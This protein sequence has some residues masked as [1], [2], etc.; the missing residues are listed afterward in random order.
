MPEEGPIKDRAK[1]LGVE[2]YVI[3]F[4]TVNSIKRP[5]S[6]IKGLSA[7]QSLVQTSLKLS[8]LTR[9]LNISIVHSNG[10]KAHFINCVAY[11]FFGGARSVVHIRDIPYTKT[12]II[13]WHIL[14]I[15]SKQVILVSKAC[16][17]GTI[18]SKKIKV[19]HNGCQTIRKNENLNKQR[20]KKP[21]NIGF[22]G[23]IHPSKGLHIL[24]DWLSTIPKDEIKLNLVIRG[25]FSEDAPDYEKNILAKIKKLNLE[26]I[27][28]F[29]GFIE[30]QNKVYED[31][32][33]V[34]VPSLIPDPLPRSVM[35]PMSKNIPV[36]GY[37]AGG[38]PEMIIHEETGFLVKNEH[39]F[40]N[41]IE[42]IIKHP[43]L[44][45][46]ITENAQKKIE[47]EFSMHKLYQDINAIYEELSSR[48]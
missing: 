16:W 3:P 42:K 44:L 8:K 35:E 23:R 19:I 36:I 34:I 24:I 11:R 10:L 22:I 28:K 21:L 48:G 27:I 46:L 31:I 14:S 13:V 33:I 47:N 29:D 7:V 40:K 30:N 1:E 15:L 5:F 20:D 32:D 6:F 37:P 17:P 25:T 12:E 38:I 41:A 4:G 2:C 43:Q 9:K 26:D 18:N 39:D 45:K